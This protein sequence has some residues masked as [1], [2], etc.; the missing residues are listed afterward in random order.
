MVR[1]AL[2]WRGFQEAAD[3]P[4]GDGASDSAAGAE[5]PDSV[6][7]VVVVSVG[8]S[9][10]VGVGLVAWTY[11]LDCVALLTGESDISGRQQSMEVVADVALQKSSSA[12]ESF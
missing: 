7:V 8:V 5:Y 11:H 12:A 4:G 2:P 9:V 3:S 10:S 1:R 6:V